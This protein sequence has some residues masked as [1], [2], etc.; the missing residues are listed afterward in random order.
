[1]QRYVNPLVD[2]I[3][4]NSQAVKQSII[5]Q[6]GF[7]E[8]RITI[9]YNGIT[10]EPF[11]ADPLRRQLQRDAL[12]VDN[13][14]IAIGSVGNI[15]PVKGYDLLVEAAG[16]VCSQMPNVHFYH[17]G[18]GDM[19]DGL[20]QRCC[21]LGIEDRFTFLG[22]VKDVPSFLKGLDIY[23]QPSRSEGLSNAILEAMSSCLPVITTDVGGNPDL[24]DS[25]I[26]GILVHLHETDIAK[27]VVSLAR[28]PEL[29]KRLGNGAYEKVLERFQ[30][31]SMLQKYYQLY[32][33]T[34]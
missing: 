27:Q 18:E 11:T 33:G 24:V 15:R 6:E 7:P 34:L 5:E 10:I 25:G 4:A 32:T 1:M 26:N 22:S 2:G 30:M 8:Q 3:L 14:T 9:I 20:R 19:L 29:R 28:N 13:D 17:A 12:G 31:S 23:I 16:T 21:E